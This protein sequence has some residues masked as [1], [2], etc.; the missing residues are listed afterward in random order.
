MEL[1]QHGRQLLGEWSANSAGT[2]FSYLLISI[3]LV[4]VV[5]YT[6]SWVPP[7]V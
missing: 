6:S 5:R 7:S 2:N 3:F 1:V 4:R